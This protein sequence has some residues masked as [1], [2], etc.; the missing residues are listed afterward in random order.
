MN[1]KLIAIIVILIASLLG[2][3]ASI[4]LKKGFNNYYYFILAGFLYFLA[5]LCIIY[6]L[7]F[8]DLSMAYP[9]S[10]TTYLW[11]SLFSMWFLKEQISK[12]RWLGI[13]FVI[14]GIIII[15]V[16]GLIR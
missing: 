1:A 4:F 16:E 13:S 8:L 15:G 10:A 5:L 7:K 14:I 12:V 9:I 6:S 2:S 11:V 3:T